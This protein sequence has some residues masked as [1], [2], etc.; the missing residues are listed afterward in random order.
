M[1]VRFQNGFTVIADRG[2]QFPLS[3]AIENVEL[4]YECSPEHM[5]MGAVR[6]Q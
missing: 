1:A 6:L 5:R 3:M 4:M 2:E